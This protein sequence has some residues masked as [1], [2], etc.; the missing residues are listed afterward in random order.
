VLLRLLIVHGHQ[1]VVGEHLDINHVG[2]KEGFHEAADLGPVDHVSV[3]IDPQ[4]THEVGDI[5]L[6]EL[7]VPAIVHVDRERPQAKPDDLDQGPAAIDPARQTDDAV[8]ALAFARFLD[9]LDQ[10]IQPAKT[11]L[12]ADRKVLFLLFEKAFAIVANAVVIELDVDRAFIH[13]ATRT[14]L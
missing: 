7:G 13:D 10:G 14:R 12:F 2:G 11:L 5:V 1:G 8:V 3:E 9:A 6:G 4:L